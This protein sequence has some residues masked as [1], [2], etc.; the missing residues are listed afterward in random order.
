MI[1]KLYFHIMP[2]K[3]ICDKYKAQKP[4]Q[5][6]DRYSYGQKRCNLCDIF[7]EWDGSRCPCCSGILRTRPRST[8][9][10]I[11]IMQQV[12]RF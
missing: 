11:K 4:A 7:I 3:G 8:R 6:N 10:R 9:H 1:Q 5:T 2:C 12:K